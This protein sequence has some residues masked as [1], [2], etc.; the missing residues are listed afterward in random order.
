M[1]SVKVTLS[2]PVRVKINTSTNS[3]ND[4]WGQIIHNVPGGRVLHTGQ[5]GYIKRVAK[6]KYNVQASI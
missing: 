1:K 6:N 2:V 5:L 4:R 3:K